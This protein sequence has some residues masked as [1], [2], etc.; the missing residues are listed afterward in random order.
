MRDENSSRTPEMDIIA[1]ELHIPKKQIRQI[2]SRNRFEAIVSRL[3]LKSLAQH[4]KIG[5][6]V[7]EFESLLEWPTIVGPRWQKIFITVSLHFASMIPWNLV[8]LSF[9]VA[10]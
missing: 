8:Q 7:P 10:S 4:G 2:Q 1:F 3:W 5:A 9:S 6:S